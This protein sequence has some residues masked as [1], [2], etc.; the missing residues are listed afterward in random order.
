MQYGQ[1]LVDEYVITEENLY[2]ASRRDNLLRRLSEHTQ[3]SNKVGA[4]GAQYNADIL[5][6]MIEDKKSVGYDGI[7][8]VQQYS[9]KSAMMIVR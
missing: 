5:S 9:T 7:L 4:I 3:P 1:N 6:V 2:N 8:D